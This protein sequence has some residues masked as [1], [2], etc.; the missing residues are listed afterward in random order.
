MLLC[1]IMESYDFTGKTVILFN[2]HEDSRP[3]Q[4]TG[5]SVENAANQ[6]KKPANDR[7]NARILLR[8]GNVCCKITPNRPGAQ[9]SLRSCAPDVFCCGLTRLSADR[10]R[11]GPGR[12]ERAEKQERNDAQ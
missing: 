1:T 3:E 8:A 12:S 2:T 9:C 6:Q 10:Q 4:E 7:Q 5:N 11:D